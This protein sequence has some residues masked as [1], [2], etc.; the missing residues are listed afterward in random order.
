MTRCG[1]ANPPPNPTKLTDARAAGYVAEFGMSCWELNALEPTVIAA[2]IE[3]A[4]R[5]V[6]DDAR[7][8]AAVEREQDAKRLLQTAADRWDDVAVW[9]AA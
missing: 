3:G 8:T 6:R 4:V 7:W 1:R 2:L 5:D 9:L